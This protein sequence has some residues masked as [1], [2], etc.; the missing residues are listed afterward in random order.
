VTDTVTVLEPRQLVA[1]LLDAVSLFPEATNSTTSHCRFS[2]FHA[3]VY[4][5][6]PHRDFQ[7]LCFSERLHP[8]RFS[9]DFRDVR[10]TGGRVPRQRASSLPALQTL[11]ASK[12]PLTSSGFSLPFLEV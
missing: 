7:T 12:V 5:S 4:L 3:P 11:A 8:Y 6:F 10:Q 1:W 2:H 9:D